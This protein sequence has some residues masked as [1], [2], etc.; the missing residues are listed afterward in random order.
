MLLRDRCLP[1]SV[2][3]LGKRPEVRSR[4][5][6]ELRCSAGLTAADV[7]RQLMLSRPTISRWEAGTHRPAPAHRRALA[8]A[9]AVP[10]TVVD[11]ALADHPAARSG[12]V[13]LPRLGHLRRSRG[14]SAREVAA[15]LGT[16][17]ST[18]SAWETGAGRVPTDRLA[19][20]ATVL[21]TTPSMLIT[22]GSSAALTVDT[23]TAWAAGRR[24]RRMSQR[25]AAAVLRISRSHLSRIENGHRKPGPRL[26]TAMVRIYRMS[27]RSPR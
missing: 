9:L 15:A 8:D 21:G 10:L 19:D 16:A 25:E 6:R 14:L 27:P 17:P 1:A 12:S 22:G 23:V 13:R 2:P 7:A 18:V 3:D 26:A 4:T 5:L 24:S 11:Q 20:L